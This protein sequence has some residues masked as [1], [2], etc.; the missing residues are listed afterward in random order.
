MKGPALATAILMVTFT[1]AAPAGDIRVQGKFVSTVPNGTPPL[2]VTSTTRVDN[3]NADTVDGFHGT[4]FYTVSELGTSGMALVHFDNI[5]DIPTDGVKNINQECAAGDGCF[6][7]DFP[8]FPV[9]IN[10][11]GSYRLTGNLDLSGEIADRDGIDVSAPNVTID[12]NGFAIMGATT[13]DG[14]PV[15]SCTPTG[16]GD[17]IVASSGLYENLTIRN[18]T[19]RGMPRHGIN[20]TERCNVENVR[21]TQNGSN[22]ISI[23]NRKGLI[24]NNV[25]YRNGNTGIRG[26][27]VFR[28]N[29]AEGNGG[30]GIFTQ[31][32]S[33]AFGNS[34]LDN[35]GNGIRC[36]SCLALDNAIHDN[37]GFGLELGGGAAYGRNMIYINDTGATTGTG[38]QVDTNLCGTATAC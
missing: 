38:L 23:S 37:V 22:G 11:P 19:I 12:L 31:P 7:G 27:G 10:Q 14:T 30:Y 5:T 16:N 15:T 35:G 3:L 8:G 33:A 1:S 28:D 2:E 20:C 6:D 17:G 9:Q 29:V 13:C 21:A 32:G 18:G 26:H 36:F 24:Q 34:V 4:D 25:A